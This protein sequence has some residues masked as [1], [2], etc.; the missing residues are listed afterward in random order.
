MSGIS[1]LEY[2][3]EVG[4]KNTADTDYQ[5]DDVLNTFFSSVFTNKPKHDLPQ[6]DKRHYNS[7]L[8]GMTAVLRQS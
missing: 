3:D 1:N 2:T 7:I 8:K 4:S 6:F 5:K